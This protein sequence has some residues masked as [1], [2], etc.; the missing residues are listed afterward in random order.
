MIIRNIPILSTKVP[1]LIGIFWVD[2]GKTEKVWHQFRHKKP[3]K[4]IFFP[5]IVTHPPQKK[6]K[7]LFTQH[8][9]VYRISSGKNHSRES[10]TGRVRSSPKGGYVDFNYTHKK[11]PVG[12]FNPFEKF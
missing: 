7:K 9:V 12:G 2:L 5:K 6:K 3:V 8:L 10:L 11:L 4:I 1:T